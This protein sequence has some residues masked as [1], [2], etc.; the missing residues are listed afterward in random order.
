M[1]W[2][3]DWHY[4]VE[5]IG[6]AASLLVSASLCLKN[7]KGLRLL[8]MAGSAVF[9]AYGLVIRSPSV[10]L[11][12]A[13]AVAVNLYHLSRLGN[14][15]KRTDLFD[16][17]FIDSLEDETLRRFVHFHGEDIIRFNP[18]FNPDLKN[19]TLAGGEYC[20]ILRET[21]PVS[22]VAYKRGADDEITIL[23]DYVIPAFRD[24]RNA[25]FFFSN[26][27]GRVASP[28]SVFTARGEVRAHI[29]YLKR[30]GFVETRREG[31]TVYFRKAV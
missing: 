1:G 9:L 19:G 3:D 6:I 29:A 17:L 27:A 12:N 13:F 5:L 14:E 26:V 28:G 31:K 7:I 21:L 23:L 2:H 25:H 10:T 8:N 18:S 4:V 30:M 24:F 20:F 16:V 15:T 22:L 11:L